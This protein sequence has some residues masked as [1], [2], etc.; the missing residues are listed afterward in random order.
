MLALVVQGGKA[1]ARQEGIAAA[2]DETAHRGRL[3]R[4][5]AERRA[6]AISVVLDDIRDQVVTLNGKTLGALADAVESRRVE[7]I[8]PDARTPVESEHLAVV[9]VDDGAP[10]PKRAPK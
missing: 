2:V 10:P 4:A 8:A 3:V 6:Q 9:P 7:A 1:K 5:E